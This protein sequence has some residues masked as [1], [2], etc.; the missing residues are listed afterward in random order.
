MYW[1]AHLD[2]QNE[3]NSPSAADRKEKRRERQDQSSREKEKA[4]K[5]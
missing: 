4:S 5:K 3:A 2:V 1:F